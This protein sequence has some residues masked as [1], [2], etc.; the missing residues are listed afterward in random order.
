MRNIYSLFLAVFIVIFLNTY[1]N[2]YAEEILFKYIGEI[3]QK[4]KYRL[5]LPNQRTVT[6]GT[7]TE[8]FEL[9]LELKSIDGNVFIGEVSATEIQGNKPGRKYTEYIKPDLRYD[10]EGYRY[11]REKKTGTIGNPFDYGEVGG[12]DIFPV[13]SS[14]PVDIGGKWTIDIYVGDVSMYGTDAVYPLKYNYTFEGIEQ[15]NNR[16]CARITYTMQGSIQ[17]STGIGGINRYDRSIQGSGVFYFEPIDGYIVYF[18]ENST[19]VEIWEERRVPYGEEDWS[20]VRTKDETISTEF[21]LE[22]IEVI[23]P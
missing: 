12:W 6:G 5:E 3:G 8:I 13:F 17:G 23:P 22:L 19:Q 14:N 10:S 4:M 16:N 7:M 20:W 1:K 9:L 11:I 2:S 18:K 21:T 15:K